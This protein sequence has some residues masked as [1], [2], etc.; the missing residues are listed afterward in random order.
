[1][2]IL[3]LSDT[4]GDT[5]AI[6]LALAAESPDLLVH[7]GDCCG[8]VTYALIGEPPVALLQV[9][10][11]CD[12]GVQMP[13]ELEPELGG[14][15]FFLLHGHTRDAKNGDS[16]MLAAAQARKAEV[17]LYGHTHVPSVERKE[18]VWLVNPGSA[19]RRAVFGRGAT[20]AVLEID[21]DRFSA[22][23]QS[24]KTDDKAKK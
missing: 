3:V 2:K 15:R 16:A 11:N 10:G 21:G 18:G 17:V 13:T 6:R 1:M 7:L 4:H 8:D 9:R 24:L 12:Y 20:Y 22:G 5:D 14:K 23:I 19:R